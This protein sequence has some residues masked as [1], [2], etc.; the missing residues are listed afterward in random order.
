MR[1]LKSGLVGQMRTGLIWWWRYLLWGALLMC[2]GELPS[3]AAPVG[4]VFVLQ[5]RSAANAN[6]EVTTYPA[7]EFVAQVRGEQFRSPPLPSI[8]EYGL[9]AQTNFKD[10]RYYALREDRLLGTLT[11]VLPEKLPTIYNSLEA[12]V[13]SEQP[14]LPL[15]DLH[16][17][18][19]TDQ[20]LTVTN[21]KPVPDQTAN[22]VDALARAALLKEGLPAGLATEVP[23]LWMSSLRVGGRP[24]AVVALYGRT[25]SARSAD[26]TLKRLVSLLI[27]AEP[28][29]EQGKTSW[30]SRLSLVGDG[31][32][33]S[34]IAY[35]PLAVA[36]LNGDGF[37][38][39]LVRQ[40]R[41]DHWQYGIY[42]FYQGSWQSRFTG[43]EGNYGVDLPNPD[44][45]ETDLV[46]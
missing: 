1:T 18:V 8:T 31:S 7:I 4:L 26:L 13:R 32:P 2:L 27:I 46:Q 16:L 10:R 42:S 14:V 43:R 5:E 22:E 35:G 9:F 45:E 3:I 25:F 23:R 33:E 44:D 28:V 6:G 40:T 29:S 30:Q 19:A 17:T 38:D 34:T 24:E 41:F 20:P 15:S 12:P 37:E 36:D 39:I 11:T 21:R